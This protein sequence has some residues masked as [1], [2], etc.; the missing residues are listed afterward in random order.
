MNLEAAIPCGLLINELVTNSL[1]H[2]FY[3]DKSGEICI[4][5]H[6]EQQEKNYLTIRD[7]DIGMPANFDWKN[8]SSLWFKLMR[9]LSKQLKAEIEFDGGVR[10][11]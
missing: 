11:Q 9:I 6:Q 8:S 7:N 4:Q 5:L 2:A 1:K 10:V 3:N